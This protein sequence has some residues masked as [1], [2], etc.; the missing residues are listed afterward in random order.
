MTGPFG[1]DFTDRQFTLNLAH[2]DSNCAADE[3]QSGAPDSPPESP[4]FGLTSMPTYG[5]F[6]MSNT[7]CP[8]ARERFCTNAPR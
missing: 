7:M 4:V 5:S 8:V 2:V 1:I 3:N 6:D